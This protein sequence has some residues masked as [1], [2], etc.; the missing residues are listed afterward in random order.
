MKCIVYTRGN[1]VSIGYISQST[2]A[3]LTDTGLGWSDAEIQREITKRTTSD[4]NIALAT[5]WAIALGRGGMTEAAAIDLLS[6]KDA[7][8]GATGRIVVEDT[9]LPAHITGGPTKDPKERYF[10]D[11][12]VWTG[13]AVVVDMPKARVVHMTQIRLARDME[14]SRLDKEWS[15]LTSDPIAQAQVEA[16][17]QVLRA[18]PQ[19]F[20]L[21]TYPTP[22]ALKAAWPLSL[23][24][25][26]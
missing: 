14:L 2:L 25:R 16:Q 7:P 26:I 3:L 5:E 12:C 9:T 6:R 10:R 20:D 19:T 1:G 8:I 13:A 21:S 15:R 23:P 17:R 4:A 11:C 24:A 22:Q 18:I